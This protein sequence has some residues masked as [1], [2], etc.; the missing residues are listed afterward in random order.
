MRALC[1]SI[2]LAMT[3]P[4]RA[5]VGRC[6]PAGVRKLAVSSHADHAGDQHPLDTAVIRRYLRR[7]VAKLQYCHD[8]ELLARPDLVAGTAVFDFVI[9]TSGAVRQ[10]AAKGYDDA[11]TACMEGFVKT[12]AFP[13]PQHATAA[14]VTVDL[15]VQELEETWA[16]DKACRKVPAKARAAADKLMTAL[17]DGDLQALLALLPAKL[18]VLGKKHKK[19][20]IEKALTASEDGLESWFGIGDGSWKL[21]AKSK[22]HVVLF[23][24]TEPASGDKVPAFSIKRSGKAWKVKAVI[25]HRDD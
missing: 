23:R 14:R 8:K 22:S 21:V 18:T 25:R 10:V 16:D 4:A 3:T 11:V 24:A 15:G 7:H 2:V 17:G 19:A 5:E 6:V 13:T 20:A 12:I 1:V 9:D